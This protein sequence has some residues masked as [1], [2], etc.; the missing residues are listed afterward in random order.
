MPEALEAWP[1]WLLER[2]VPRHLQIIE[3]INARLLSEVE[4]RWPGDIDRVRRMSILDED[5]QKHVRMAH[6]AIVGSHAVNGV[7][8]LH[9]ELVKTSL[10]P[11]FA[12]LWPHKFQ[13]VTNGVTPRRWLLHANPLL[14]DSITRRIGDGW[15][16]DLDAL[17]ALEPA[18]EDAAF[19]AEFRAVKRANKERLAR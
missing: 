6:L 10:V 19:R 13:N 9:S 16:R 14:A 12:E 4:V 8:A 15:V 18:A 5:P 1:S 11:D 7:S 2:V 17:R 3:E